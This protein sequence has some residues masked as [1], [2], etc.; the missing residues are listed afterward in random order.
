MTALVCL[1]D[2]V[3]E[4]RPEVSWAGKF[5]RIKV[6]LHISV[7]TPKGLV[8]RPECPQNVPPFAAQVGWR[9]ES[10]AQLHRLG[11]IY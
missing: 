11:Y 10:F 3:V 4:Q 6:V 2:G 9:G 1:V 7:D 8:T 5:G